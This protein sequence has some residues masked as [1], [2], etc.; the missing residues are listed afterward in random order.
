MRY[1]L[2]AVLAYSAMVL[3]LGEW[4]HGETDAS[5]SKSVEGRAM[6][7]FTLPTLQ[8][9]SASLTNENLSRQVSL[10]NVWASW[11]PACR[12][13]H[14]FLVELSRSGPVPIFG[15][16]YVDDRGNALALL[17]E[18][19]DP[20]VAS[21]FDKDGDVAHSLGVHGAPVT[22]LID[23]AGTIQYSHPSPLTPEVWKR[24]FLPRIQA[25]HGAKGDLL[26]SYS[27]FTNP[28]KAAFIDAFLAKRHTGG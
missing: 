6:P 2:V 7:S 1:Y 21:G 16:N 11:C 25:S 17:S 12:Q 13:E 22:F 27:F 9:A 15:L 5:A 18:L 24:E 28:K 3:Y 20:Y 10:L 4:V 14:P 19:G 8:D 23:T 26:L